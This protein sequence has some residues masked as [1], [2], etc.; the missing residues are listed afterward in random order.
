MRTTID[1][2]P[3]LHERIKSYATSRGESFSAVAAQAMARGMAPIDTPP[4]TQ[5]DPVTG[6]LTFDFGRGRR[7][8]PAE[9]ADL[10]DEDAG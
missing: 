6:L 4:P 10:I 7:I 9:V 2:P 3:G 1:I 5:V 8:T